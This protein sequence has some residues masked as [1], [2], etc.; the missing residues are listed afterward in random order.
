MSNL[1]LQGSVQIQRRPLKV[2]SM[3]PFALQKML[4]NR[5]PEQVVQFVGL[6][7]SLCGQAQKSAA[8]LVLNPQVDAP[9]R[10]TMALPVMVES[11]KEHFLAL[12]QL[13]MQLKL[14]TAEQSTQWMQGVG[15][16]V[17]ESLA[18]SRNS[19]AGEKAEAALK[20]LAAKIQQSFLQLGADLQAAYPQ[21]A[22]GSPLHKAMQAFECE[23]FQGSI[24]LLSGLHTSPLAVE[25]LTQPVESW[26]KWVAAPTLA[27]EAMENSAWSRVQARQAQSQAP[28]FESSVELTAPLLSCSQKLSRFL[29]QRLMAKVV[30]AAWWLQ[31]LQD[32]SDAAHSAEI[33]HLEQVGNCRYAWVETARGRLMHWAQV[34]E[35]GQVQHYAI[36]APTEWN[37]HPQGVMAQALRALPQKLT[38]SCWQVNAAL[39]AQV[40]DPCV[41][42]KFIHKEENADA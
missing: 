21:C 16:W 35:T 1:D 9:A 13:L 18:L 24:Q 8:Q 22:E 4:Q 38:E 19:Q 10:S 34:A 32:D 15:Q 30:D 23:D 42:L 26:S 33:F 29:Q 39:I 25:Q 3:R 37:F 28:R 40:I 27:K 14:C 36:C 5:T 12:V 17:P 7:Y 2:A 11:L 20:P 31:R 41:P 6:A